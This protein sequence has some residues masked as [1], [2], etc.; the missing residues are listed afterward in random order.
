MLFWFHVKNAV[1]GYFFIRVGHFIFI[2][3][4]FEI[5]IHFFFVFC[6]DVL[7]L[8]LFYPDSGHQ[9]RWKVAVTQFVMQFRELQLVSTATHL[10]FSLLPAERQIALDIFNSLFGHLN[11]PI[12]IG[13]LPEKWRVHQFIS[14]C[15]FGWIRMLI[16]DLKDWLATAENLLPRLNL[17]NIIQNIPW[18]FR[19]PIAT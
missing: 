19:R 3:Q 10:N 18:D 2:V 13:N 9:S 5:Q 7:D 11:L 15:V 1:S 12:C 14:F 16:N 6:L 8:L 4:N 17:H